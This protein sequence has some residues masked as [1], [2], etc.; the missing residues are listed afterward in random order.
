MSTL[1]NIIPFLVA[2]TAAA[3]V[4][5]LFMGLYVMSAPDAVEARY[6]N[7]MM[8]WRVGLQGASLALIALWFAMSG[9]F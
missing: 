3:T 7:L 9:Y 2:I 8:R 5:A 4:V 1:I 6:S